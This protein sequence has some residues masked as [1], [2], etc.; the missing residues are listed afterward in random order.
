M[1]GL[2]LKDLLQE[3]RAIGIQFRCLGHVRFFYNPSFSA[4]FFSRNSVFSHNKSAGTVFR[5]V[6]SAKRTWPLLLALA[7]S[8][9]FNL[10]CQAP[11]KYFV[12]QFFPGCFFESIIYIVISSMGF[13]RC[14]QIAATN[15][16]HQFINIQPAFDLHYVQHLF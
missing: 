13:M 16:F 9:I 7:H 1:W 2:V 14:I 3:A 15:K 10:V 6:F 11:C 4:C 8:F 12:Q 5:L